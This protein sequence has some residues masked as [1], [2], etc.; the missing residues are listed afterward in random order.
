MICGGEAE[1]LIEFV[2]A[3]DKLLEEIIGR[4]L[5]LSTNRTPGYLFTYMSV[6]SGGQI[7]GPVEHLLVEEHGA[8][9]GNIPEE[10]HLL[11]MMPD[12]RLLKP[13][14]ILEAQELE[15]PVLL[16]WLRPRGTVFIFGAGHVG[17][18]VAHLASY[19]NFRVVVLD[20]RADFASTERIPDAEHVIILTSF[21]N[22]FLDLVVD[23]ESFIVI[24]TRGHSHDRTVLAQALR[25]TAGYIGMIGSRRKNKIVFERLLGDGFTR[26]D[27][28]RVHAP[29]GLSIGGETPE[30]IGIAIVGEMIQIRNRKDQLKHL[31]A[32][33]A[34]GPGEKFC[35]SEVSS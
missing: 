18:S 9:I 30:E 23:E 3:G 25:T 16:E 6:P 28:E 13:C 2:P 11:K 1:V 21:D 10:E 35:S 8:A 12:R 7:T 33:P 31:G 27:I 17:V 22:A 15:Y 20:D 32:T 4:V 34:N 24:V 14:Q 29:I 5:T 19:V 26:E